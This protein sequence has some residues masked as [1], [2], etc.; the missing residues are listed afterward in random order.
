MEPEKR[1]REEW[2]SSE[3]TTFPGKTYV[4]CLLKPLFNDQ[5]DTLFQAMIQVHRAHV[6]MLYDRGIL[7][8]SEATRILRAVE[9]VARTDPKALQY[10]PRYEDLFFLVEGKIAERIGEELAG[11]YEEIDLLY[12]ISELLGQTIHLEEAARTILREVSAVVAARRASL[13]VFDEALDRLRVVATR[14]FPMPDDATVAPT[15]PG[16]VAARA[17]RERRLVEKGMAEAVAGI[18]AEQVDVAAARRVEQPVDARAGRQVGFHRPHL[19]AEILQRGRGIH[20]GRVGDDEQVVALLRG[21]AG[22]LEADSARRAGDDGEFA[23][24]HGRAPFRA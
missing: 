19:D 10:D 11:R 16:S 12:T 17:F 21:E 2:I 20:Q 13:M 8:K 1:H 22:E 7:K 5:R 23:L 4:E 14:G 9:A 18:G 24:A 15:D 3:G 6:L